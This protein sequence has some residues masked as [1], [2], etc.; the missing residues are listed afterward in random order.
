MGQACAQA[1]SGWLRL[2]SDQRYQPPLGV[3]VTVDVPLCS[4]NGP[5]TG[6]Q[7]NIAQRATGLMHQPCRSRDGGAPTR[8]R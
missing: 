1:L 2:I 6:E 8:M 7:L 4:L 5:V 3:A